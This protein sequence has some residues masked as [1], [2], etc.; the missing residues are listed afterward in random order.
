MLHRLWL[1]LL[2]G[3]AACR[4]SASKVEATVL[5]GRGND[6]LTLDP[7]CVTDSESAEVTEQIFDHLVRYKRASTEIEPGLALK[8]EVSSDGKA[9]TFH[10]RPNVRFHDGTPLDADAVVFSFD[11]QRDPTHPF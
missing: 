6:V 5:V 7:A 1:I 9:W 10:L 8:W 2:V 3:S 11:R 4:P